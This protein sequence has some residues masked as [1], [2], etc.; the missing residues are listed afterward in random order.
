MGVRHIRPEKSEI[1]YY[2][3]AVSE[4]TVSS[5]ANPLSFLERA[6][7]WLFRQR[8]WIPAPLIAALVVVPF[9]QSPQ[10]QGT[11]PYWAIGALLVLA[12]ESLRLWGVRHIGVISRTRSE[13]LG[14]L[15]TGGP[16]GIMR[17]PLYVGNIA[18]WAGFAVCE[19][20]LW[21]AL[22]VTLLLSAEYH[23]IVLWEESL[24]KVHRG[25]N[26]RDY[27]R[28]VPRWLPRFRPARAPLSATLFSWP[29]TLFSERGTL[30]A[31]AAGFLLL[32]LKSRI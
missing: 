27:L 18:L 12:G 4:P 9:G 6:G 5:A 31:I 32:W 1:I 19:R 16:F 14:P 3:D 8:T 26:Y 21:L 2:S 29:D 23:A 13:R 25:E 11:A 22:A 10:G 24:L 7:G 28:E 20:R 30:I 15:V 17:N